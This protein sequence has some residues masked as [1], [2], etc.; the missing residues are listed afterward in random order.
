MLCNYETKYS[1]QCMNMLR[2]SPGNFYWCVMVCTKIKLGLV[3]VMIGSMYKQ[4]TGRHH[5]EMEV[6]SN[7]G[8]MW[9][10]YA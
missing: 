9:T 8:Q 2:L 6:A 5:K 1:N 10:Q 7:R 3:V 4:T